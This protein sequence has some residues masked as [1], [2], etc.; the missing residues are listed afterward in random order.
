MGIL[1]SPQTDERDLKGTW[2][3]NCTSSVFGK[4]WEMEI[5][6]EASDVGFIFITIVL[7]CLPGKLCKLFKNFNLF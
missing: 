6:N 1:V 3:N 4:A 2:K 7:K 5:V